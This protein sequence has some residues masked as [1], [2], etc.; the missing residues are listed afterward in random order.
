M[1]K[2]A[3][4]ALA[5][6]S[7]FRGE[8]IGADGQ[9]VGEVVFNTAMTGY[10]EILTDPSYAQQIVTLTYPHIGN[11]G[12][13]PEDAE[14][15]RVW[16]AGLVIRDLPLVASNWRN[17]MPLAEYLKANKTVAIAGI[18]TRRLTR[19]LREKGAQNG[20]IMAGDNISEEAA[21]AAARAF[22]GLKG[23]DLAKEVSTKETYEW[24]ST[25]WNLQSDSSPEVAAADLKYHVV[26]WDYGVKLNILRMLV[27]RGCRV[28]VVPAQTPASEVLALKPDGIFLS[29]GPGDPEPCDYAIQAIKDVLETDI[30]VFGICLG[31]QLLALASGA[32]TI[33][34][35]LGHHGANHPVQD[36]DTGVVMITSQNHGFAVDEATLPSNVRAIHKSLFDG[37]LQGIERTDKDAFSFQGHPEAS[38]GP[39]DVAPL[40]DRFITAMD[41]RR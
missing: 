40:F 22:P 34:M 15:D 17:K 1:T 33:K 18:D 2:P 4:L 39:T 36:L 6:G 13:T 19:I 32:R 31:H 20:C 24:R 3:I 38:P 5:D 7:I 16:S 14:S 27:E 12:T 8:A 21:I 30:P 9:T 23:M 41:K 11:T 25:V 35:D 29:N 28:T 26:A 10:Q 37:S